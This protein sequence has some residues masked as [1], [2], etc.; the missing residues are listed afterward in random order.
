MRVDNLVRA[1]SELNRLTLSGDG[2][3]SDLESVPRSD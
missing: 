1:R 3:P 2:C